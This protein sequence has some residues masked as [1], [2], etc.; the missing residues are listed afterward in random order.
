MAEDLESCDLR[1][2]VDSGDQYNVIIQGSSTTT[3]IT[4]D[5]YYV[6]AD[7][8]TS[9]SFA[10]TASFALSAAGTVTSSDQVITAIDG[11]DITPSSVT[12]SFFGP[13]IGTASFATTALTV[14]QTS[15]TGSFTGSFAGIHSG[16]GS[17]LIFETIHTSQSEDSTLVVGNVYNN[18]ENKQTTIFKNGDVVVSGSTYIS[19][20]GLLV[21]SP[22]EAPSTFVSGGMFYSSS[23]EFFV[24][25]T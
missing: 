15:F 13:L 1:V 4:D 6:V 10:E 7:F 24:G 9:A 5:N 2:I 18:Y 12:S 17:G 21:F 25:I 16:N 20:E 8:A 11:Q 22:R 14:L 23:G 3:Q 19:Q